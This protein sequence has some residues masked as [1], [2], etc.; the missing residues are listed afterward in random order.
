MRGTQFAELS[1][2]VAVAEQKSFTRAAQTLG[3]STATLSQAIRSLEDRLGVRLLN[4]TTRSVGLTS[5][6]ERLLGRLRPVLDDY[7]GA[8]E[9]IND[10]R[11][12][13]CGLLRLTVLP[14]ASEFMLAP[15]LGRFLAQYS[16]IKL[17]VLAE[18]A[19]QDIV[20]QRFDAGIRVG[21]R[22]ERDMVA[23]R[24]SG[25]IRIVT[26]ASPAYLAKHG[27]PEHPQDLRDHDCIRFRFPGGGMMPL[28]FEK[29]GKRLE[30]A[31]EGSLITNDPR[32][33]V[34]VAADDGGVFYTAELYA[35][36]LMAE[37]KLIPVLED[38]TPPPDAFYLYYPS[39][40]QNPAALQALIEFLK[41]NLRDNGAH[42][43]RRQSAK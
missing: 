24:V 27:T 31:V 36:E 28:R 6:G 17:E 38:W 26:V 9:S 15:V 35:R 43:E 13:P 41:A 1:A 4:R 42:H 21:Q 20:A 40:R 25:D 37:R 2:F 18:P 23:V 5:V 3:I 11:D 39:R 33:G 19:L 14:P 34:S 7:E 10:F 12:R 30:V 16:D 29:K 22:V 8:L 32:L